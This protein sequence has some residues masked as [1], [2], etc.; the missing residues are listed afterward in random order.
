[1]TFNLCLLT[2][3]AAPT[4]Q[5]FLAALAEQPIAGLDCLAID[6]S[7]DDNTAELLAVAGF[8]VHTIPRA[9]FN[10]GATRQLAV[11][12]APAA[13]ILIFLTQDAIL[14]DPL[15]LQRLVAAFDDPRVGAAYG[16][17][18]PQRDATPVAAHARLFNYP[19]ASSVRA[20]ADILR[21]GI[22]TAFLSNS[23]AAYRR[24]ALMAVGGF[25]RDVIL[26][27]DTWVAA[28]ML[29][30][31]WKIAYCADATCYHSHNYT[32]RQ[33]L[34]RYFD[35]GVFHT[36]EAWYLDALGRAEGEGWRFVLS[37]WR[38][39]LRH[40]P[41][42]LPAAWLRM[43]CKWLGYRLGRLERFLPTVLKRRLSMHPGFWLKRQE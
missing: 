42:K 15:A 1:M 19:D 29:L 5:P 9:S 35:I 4:L 26:G 24:S 41:G 34:R 33:E 13:D 8:R 25:P 2:L 40:A 12:L 28:R 43:G 36:Q 23:C 37:E 7:S 38:Y 22:K 6:S 17:Q 27:E 32:S 39:L 21:Y 30:A 18:L 20:R 11:E 16:R 3:N 31:G 10:H 14:A